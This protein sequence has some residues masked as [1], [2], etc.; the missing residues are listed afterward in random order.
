MKE[1]RF[2]LVMGRFVR[3]LTVLAVLPV[4]VMGRGARADWRFYEEQGFALDAAFAGGLSF[5]ASPG[6]QFGAGTYQ[7]GSN[8]PI[9]KNPVWFESFI[10]PGLK[11]SFVSTSAGEFYG[12]ASAVGAITRGDGDANLVASTWG[13]PSHIALE[14]AFVG[15]RSGNVLSELGANAL[16]VRAGRQAFQVGDAFLIGDGTYNAGARA[17]NYM[18][19]R[20]AFDGLGVASFDTDPVRGDLFLLRSTTDQT[21]MNGLDFPRTDFVGANVEWFES[22]KDGEGRFAYADRARYAGLMAMYV[23]DGDSAGCF[24]TANCPGGA[25]AISSSADRKGL[26]VLSARFGGSVVPALPDLSLYGEYAYEYNDRTG[27]RVRANGWYAEPGWSFSA[28]PWTP[29][30]FYRYSHFSGD[31]NPSDGTKRSFDPLFYTAGRGYGTWFLGE[32][33]GQSFLFNSNQNTHQLGVSAN[34]ARDLTL[35]AFFYSIFYDQ[36]GQFGGTA[37]HALDELDFIVQWAITDK[38]SLSGAQ[39]VAWS[40]KGARQFLQSAVSNFPNPATNFNRTWYLT[41]I[42]LT[43]AF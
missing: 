10:I 26:G 18:A 2:D 30:V 40:G 8:Q 33:A 4:I 28:T 6:A 3:L 25:S 36:P 20:V 29:R 32:I 37:S 21:L 39:S 24:S 5:F 1:G 11:A 41:E 43:Y 9:A 16:D 22:K 13:N 17:A 12:A 35:S 14:D 19:P 38:I 31:G 27:D 42:T 7:P 15:W 23:Y 34:P